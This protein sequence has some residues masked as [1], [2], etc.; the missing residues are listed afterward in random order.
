MSSWKNVSSGPLT[1]GFFSVLGAL[2]TFRI[3][4]PSQYDLQMSNHIALVVFVFCH[5]FL[6]CAEAFQFDVG[7]LVFYFAAYALDIICKKSLPT[8]MSGSIILVFF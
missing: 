5:S 4:A 8:P 1:I 7:P 6:C 2:Y 3:L